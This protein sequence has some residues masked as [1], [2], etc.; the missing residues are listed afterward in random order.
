MMM[1]SINSSVGNGLNTY[2]NSVNNRDLVASKTA[3]TPKIEEKSKLDT[4][5]EQINNGTYKLLDSSDL[6]KKMYESLL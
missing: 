4:I 5:K 3:E 6:A 1:G 2:S